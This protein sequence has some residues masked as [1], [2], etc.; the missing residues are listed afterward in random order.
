MD[1]L[2]QPKTRRQR[3]ILAWSP[4]SSMV[5]FVSYQMLPPQ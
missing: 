4:D 2:Q 3:A 1:T 5:A